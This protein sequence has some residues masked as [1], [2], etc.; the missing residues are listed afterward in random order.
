M[1]RRVSVIASVVLC[2]LTEKDA[3][4]EEHGFRRI[5]VNIYGENGGE[6]DAAAAVFKCS[7]NTTKE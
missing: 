3:G 2:M 1:Q 7:R 6:E 5:D 4:E